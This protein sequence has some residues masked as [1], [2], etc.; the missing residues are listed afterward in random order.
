MRTSEEIWQEEQELWEKTNGGSMV[1]HIHHAIRKSMEEAIR[2]AAEV[3]KSTSTCT[4]WNCEGESVDKQS[5]LNLL[6]Q[7]K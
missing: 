5:I 2:E 4:V 6:N 1:D 3:A 7:I